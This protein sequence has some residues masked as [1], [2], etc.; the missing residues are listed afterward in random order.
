VLVT[1]ALQEQQ[2]IGW[3][4]CLHGYLSH[5]WA[6]AVAA[7]PSPPTPRKTHSSTSSDFGSIWARKTISELWA[8]ARE[9]WLHRNSH[10]HDPSSADSTKMMGAA[11]NAAITAL[12]EQVDTYS[13]Q[14]RWRFDMP[15]ALCLCTRLRS[16]HCWLALTKILTAKS[17]NLDPQGQSRLT[18][19]FQVISS[20][21]P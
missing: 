10:L 12:Y 15:L 16:R 14:D 18:T 19:Y 7:H 1:L 5:H 20:L 2:A 8:F 11:V 6:L 4:L 13:A 9:M 3:G 17:S 21:R